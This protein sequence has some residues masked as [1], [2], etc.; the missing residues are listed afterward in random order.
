M[1]ATIKDLVIDNWYS[2]WEVGLPLEATIVAVE[3]R[4]IYPQLL[5]QH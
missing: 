3:M 4:T 1:S 5:Y 2:F